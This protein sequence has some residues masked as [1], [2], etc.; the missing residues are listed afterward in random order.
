MQSEE[1]KKEVE[2]IMSG[3]KHL[4]FSAL[5]AFMT[6]PKHFYAYK[7]DKETTKAM[8]AG[9]LF[10]MA[11]LES[12]KFKENYWVLDDSEKC[13]E[14]INN[15]SKSPR[16]TTIYKDWLSA[17][18]SKHEGQEMIS[19]EDYDLYLSMGAYLHQN[20]ATKH[21]MNGLIEKE[22]D[23]EFEHL[24]FNVKGKIDGLGSD[25][26]I[27]LKKV[28]D[29]SF[30]KVRWIIEDMMYDMQ[31][32]IYCASKRIKKYY[33]IFIDSS[34]SVT[35]V[36]LSEGSIQSGFGKFEIALDEFRRCAEEDL[37][38][39]SYEFFNGGFIEV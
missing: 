31:G 11:I 12:E 17:E 21:L 1:F 30:K 35:V 34:C 37:F 8:E 25:Y 5:K 38:N 3:E 20:N 4:S 26:I 28:A 13:A 22:S 39:S 29:A 9:K 36:K 23:F 16:A 19:K 6:S 7:T 15:G 27:D 18:V 24:G 2:Q 14:L 33:L 10:H 32:G